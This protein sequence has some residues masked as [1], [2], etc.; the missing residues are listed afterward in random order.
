M[1]MFSTLTRRLTCLLVAS[2]WI[3]L[4]LAPGVAHAQLEETTV[5]FTFLHLN[6]VYEITPLGG[7]GGLARVA[8]LH[9]RLLKN[10]PNT[11]MVL[12]GDLFSPSALGTARVA[13]ERLAGKQIVAIMNMVGLDYMTFGNHEFDLSEE[14]FKQRMAEARFQWFSSNAMDAQGQP[15]PNVP[16]YRIVEVA[17]GRGK[18]IKIG[19]FGLTLPSNPKPYVRYLDIFEEAGKQVQALR[20][21]VDVLIAM[22]H[23]AFDD[24]RKLAETY[25]QI[26]L[27]IG[28]HEHVYH[29]FEKRNQPPIFK[30]DANARTAYLHYF[31]Y[32]TAARRLMRT[33]I[34]RKLAA[35]TP[36]DGAVKKE[37][38][39][40]VT[41]AFDG[42]RKDGFQPE[43]RVV[44]STLALDGTEES[45]RSKETPLTK[46]IAEGMLRE[47][48]GAELALYNGGAIRIDD[49]LP[50]GPI[51]EYDVIRILPF[52]GKVVLT[53]IRGS[54]LQKILD[55]GVANRGIGGYLQAANVMQGDGGSG[56][57]IAGAP[58]EPERAYRVAILDFL[59]T[60]R[61][62]NLGF[63]TRDAEGVR[64]VREGL[65]I[66]QTTI[67][68]FKRV[69]P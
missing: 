17:N 4:L 59:L 51:T 11:F 8:T 42:F 5:R 64:V 12:A 2:F 41:I 29:A 56:W 63:L 60:G 47:T 43:Q 55:Q 15:F 28:G 23:L 69:F 27:I 46:L 14:Q 13:G 36:E 50:P 67:N 22:T 25:P 9:K 66:R 6:D 62:Q 37:V 26:D 10:N 65:D 38:E 32:D 33:S 53:E 31:A 44:T 49:T 68:Q 34:L 24:D 39:K 16:A 54:L 3:G 57:R 7:E 35:D 30:A 20:P 61:E 52:G 1:K 18:K 21:Q 40:W 45:V 48:E 19:L 58:L